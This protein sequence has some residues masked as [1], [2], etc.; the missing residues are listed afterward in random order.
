MRDTHI[1]TERERERERERRQR[2]QQRENQTP[3]RE[4]DVG[5]DPQAPGSCPVPTADTQPLSRP[6]ILVITSILM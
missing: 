2:H 3:H 1:H 4:P 5:L 6:G